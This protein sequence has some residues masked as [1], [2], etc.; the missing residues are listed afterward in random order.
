MFVALELGG[1][2]LQYMIAVYNEAM[3]TTL[4]LYEHERLTTSCGF[5]LLNVTQ[6]YIYKPAA[7]MW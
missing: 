1:G 4:C 5:E 2:N 3:E 7:R 6:K